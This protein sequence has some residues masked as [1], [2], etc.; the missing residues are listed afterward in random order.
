MHRE[1]VGVPGVDE[2]VG[3]RRDVG[4]DPEPG[5]GV[6]ALP[7][8]AP[9]VGHRR[10]AR[11][12]RPVAP[13]H[14]RRVDPLRPPADVGERHERVIG[15]RVVHG[16]AGRAVVHRPPGGVAGGG[17]VRLQLGLPVDPDAPPG[18]AGEVEVVALR[19]PL[20]VDAVVL[21]AVRLDPRAEPGRAQQVDAGA[22]Q[23]PGPDPGGDVLLRPRLDDD[24]LDAVLREE[25]GEQQ[26]RRPR[27]DDGN[28]S[29]HAALY[30]TGGNSYAS[31]LLPLNGSHLRPRLRAMPWAATC[32]AGTRRLRLRRSGTTMPSDATVCPATLTGMAI[33]HAP[34]VISSVV[35]A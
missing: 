21:V 16:R 29:P 6:D 25:V 3:R 34:R 1:P 26:A 22:F 11:P 4:E 5:V 15:L 31:K 23:D 28:I 20:Q 10:P 7:G 17:Q 33:E 19:R 14:G 27:P 35:V 30:R 18:Q 24:R 2:L 13:R 12:E 32:I 8:V 9:A